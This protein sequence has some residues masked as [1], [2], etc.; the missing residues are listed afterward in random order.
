MLCFWKCILKRTHQ[1]AIFYTGGSVSMKNTVLR[2][3]YS[4]E[5]KMEAVRLVLEKK[6]TSRAV[7][8][9]LGLNKGII[10]RRVKEYKADQHDAFPGKG[11]IRADEE[12]IRILRR[13]NEIL[14]RERDILEK[15]VAIFSLKQNKDLD[16]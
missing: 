13:D 5:F 12:V 7:E 8:R 11:N 10:Y 4:K 9:E 6:R 14:R 1:K 2:K 3:G 16:S 15:A